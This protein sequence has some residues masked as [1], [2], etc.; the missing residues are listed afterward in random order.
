M[1]TLLTILTVLAVVGCATVVVMTKEE[2][3]LLALLAIVGAVAAVW[4]FNVK[5]K[6]K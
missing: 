1:K 4:N 5:T 2:H 3:P 6:G